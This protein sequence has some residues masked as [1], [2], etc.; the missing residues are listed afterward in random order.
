MHTINVIVT[1]SSSSSSTLTCPETRM[2][3]SIKSAASLHSPSSANIP[4]PAPPT[5]IPPV[6]SLITPDFDRA[7]EAE[8]VEAARR[9]C[10]VE[11]AVEKTFGEN[12]LRRGN[13]DGVEGVG[14]RPNAEGLSD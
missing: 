13:G 3:T 1:A 6:S 9:T 10:G 7:E 14:M 2:Q 8:W 11:G 12:G 4:P 5:A